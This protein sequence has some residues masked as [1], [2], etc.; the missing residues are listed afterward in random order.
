MEGCHN[1]NE[2]I[3]ALVAPFP[4]DRCVCEATEQV[5]TLFPAT[6]HIFAGKAR[7]W[8]AAWIIDGKLKA[9]VTSSYRGN[10]SSFRHVIVQVLFSWNILMVAFKWVIYL[11]E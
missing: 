2:H 10:Q 9:P 3:C 6:Q 8:A 4:R 11:S 7:P 5:S 1:L